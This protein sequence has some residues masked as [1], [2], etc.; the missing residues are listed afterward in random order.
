[1]S[2]I[3]FFLQ[4][5]VCPVHPSQGKQGSSVKVFCVFGDRK[6]P[7]DSAYN[8]GFFCDFGVPE[9][10]LTIRFALYGLLQ[11][12]SRG[13]KRWFQTE[14]DLMVSDWF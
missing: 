14:T 11:T 12:L 1:M 7:E 9:S 6:C 5:L 3:F 13:E 10:V 4:V 8:S 2:K